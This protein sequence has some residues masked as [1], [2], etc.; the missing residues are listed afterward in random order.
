MPLELARKVLHCDQVIKRKKAT[1]ETGSIFRCLNATSS[2]FFK[3]QYVMSLLLRILAVGEF[4]RE[5]EG[6]TAER[7]R[8]RKMRMEPSSD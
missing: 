5:T 4:N 3:M 8:E 2:E 7:E 6:R 1:V